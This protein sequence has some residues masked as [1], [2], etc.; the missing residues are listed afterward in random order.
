[1]N[2]TLTK[3]TLKGL[4]ARKSVLLRGRHGLGKSEVVR[5]T[6]Q[7][8]S[9]LL[10]KPF[11]FVDIRLSQREPGDIIG[12]PRSID[13]YTVTRTVFENGKTS[14][15][16][17]V[18]TN[19]MTHDLPVWFP[20]DPESCGYLFLDEIDRAPRE[21]QQAGF[22][23][24]LDY[25]LNLH[26]LP[27]GWRVIAA[28]NADMDIYSVL[29]MDPALLDRFLVI[30]F[31]PTVEEWLTYARATGVHK[32]IVKYVS[33]VTRDLDTPEQIEP[34][35]VYQSRRAW[36]LLSE[37][38]QNMAEMGDDPLKDLDYLT[39][40]SGGYLGQS[41]GVAF[42]EY[43]RS[44]YK[45]YSPQDILNKWSKEMKED[46]TAMLVNEVTFY[47]KELVRYI[48][49]ELPGNLNPQQSGNL[50]KFFFALDK[51]AASGFWV[52][53]CTEARDKAVEWYHHDKELPKYVMGF[54]GQ[55]ALKAKK[56][57][58]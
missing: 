34:G 45:V 6:A 33:K 44:D 23:V 22:E 14:T 51:E 55:G 35:K 30:D 28:A 53:F 38:L 29:S 9:Q 40:L 31:R 5:Q 16:P 19:V 46:F 36:V 52:H 11:H 50:K 43:V 17:E 25:R 12:M 3:R 54:L 10:G 18:L 4:P 20:R 15:Q 24:V 41:T 49:D 7:E 32:A 13:S 37:V 26:D 57:D 39:L 1:M 47:T 27:E 58:S 2:V 48:K 42:T 8:M 56:E 21:V